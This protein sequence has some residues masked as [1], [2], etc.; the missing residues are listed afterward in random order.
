MALLTMFFDLLLRGDRAKRFLRGF[1]DI[2]IF[3]M[4][5]VDVSHR[6]LKIIVRNKRINEFNF[7][8]CN[9]LSYSCLEYPRHSHLQKYLS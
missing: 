3:R 6:Q 7:L 4:L 2:M 8:F 5:D 9:K 1:D